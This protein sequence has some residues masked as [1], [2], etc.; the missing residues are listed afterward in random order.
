MDA[1]LQCEPL[2][3]QLLD[4]DQQFAEL[5]E[6]RPL[7]MEDG[8]LR[9]EPEEYRFPELAPGARYCLTSIRVID[10]LGVVRKED[11]ANLTI[12]NEDKLRVRMVIKATEMRTPWATLIIL[13]EPTTP[14][15]L[16]A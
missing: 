6:L 9:F 8:K 3:L 15:T 14:G 5:R 11:P 2:F 16:S 1:P 4:G 7:A 13:P 10:E 12:Y